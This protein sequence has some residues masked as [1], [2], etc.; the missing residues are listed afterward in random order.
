[1]PVTVLIVDR[2]LSTRR[3]LRFALEL[4]DVGIAE[5]DGATA[6]LALLERGQVDLMIVAFE[7]P[8]E[9]HVGIIDQVR[10]SGDFADLPIMLVGD[11]RHR[12][13]RDLREL[14]RCV[15]LD[16]PF[17]VT[18]VHERLGRLID[19]LPRPVPPGAKRKHGQSGV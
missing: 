4:Q 8:D 14:G 6:A 12:A 10:G 13:F 18:D 5:A 9:E 11:P 7:S 17:R 16:K 19:I 3:M 2:Q 1:M 15:W